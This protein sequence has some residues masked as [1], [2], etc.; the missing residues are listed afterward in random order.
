M[1]R[2]LLTV[3]L[4]LVGCS[5]P[6]SGDV[7]L[8]LRP[9]QSWLLTGEDAPVLATALSQ[10]RIVFVPAD[11]ERLIAIVGGSES[12]IT[13]F[14]GSQITA[15][16]SD[17]ESLWAG[18]AS[19]VYSINPLSGS[20]TT[21]YTFDSRETII[22]IAVTRELVCAVLLADEE[23]GVTC[24][25]RHGE[26]L[27]IDLPS[28]SFGNARVT[29]TSTRDGTVLVQAQRHPF[30]LVQLT[31]G[32]RESWSFEPEGK[33]F[34]SIIAGDSLGWLV[35]AA[36]PITRNRI[37]QWYSNV[38]SLQRLAL[39]ISVPDGNVIKMKLIEGPLGLVQAVP[40]EQGSVLGSYEVPH[41]RY[42][43]VY[44]IDSER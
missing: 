37:L 4:A 13:S 21:A 10:D 15:L 17:S 5:E 16:A 8:M 19:S 43:T 2:V 41:G 3:C 29:V 7:V 22:S 25:V 30:R 27:T 40:N 12:E 36:V 33:E 42:L 39:V 35:Q 9:M 34:M 31:A 32:Q 38:H 20:Q 18:V 1:R 14:P 28:L 11:Q 44:G 26:S 24:L 23:Y 6:E